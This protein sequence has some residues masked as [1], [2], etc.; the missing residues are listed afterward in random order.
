MEARAPGQC[1]SID[2]SSGT[3][4]SKL[5]IQRTEDGVRKGWGS[6]G[7]R[8]Q[9]VLKGGCRLS[10][11]DIQT[12]ERPSPGTDGQWENLP[13]HLSSS[14]NKPIPSSRFS[15]ENYGIRIFLISPII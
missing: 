13:H 14:P 2:S 15:K 4:R 8:S 1:V 5:P 9:H 10:S 11:T 12:V 7:T 3:D 6:A